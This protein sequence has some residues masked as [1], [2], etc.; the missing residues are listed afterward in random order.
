[1]SKKNIS[2]HDK[3]NFRKHC[4]NCF[5]EC[6][7]QIYKRFP[8]NLPDING[9]RFLSIVQPQNLTKINSIAPTLSAF[10]I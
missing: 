9:L 1:M 6:A 10:P 2:V 3:V 4:L 8:F 5:V 7:A